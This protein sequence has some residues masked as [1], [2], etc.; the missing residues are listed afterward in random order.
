MTPDGV[1]LWFSHGALFVTPLCAVVLLTACWWR[2][3]RRVALRAAA[4]GLVW[5]ASFGFHYVFE[6]R[7]LLANPYL[8]NYWAFAFPPSSGGVNATMHWWLG[9]FEPFALKP[10]GTGRWVLFWMASI[11]GFVFAIWHRPMFGLMLI[12]VPISAALLAMLRIVPPHERLGLWIVPALY[13]S[14][15]MC[16]DA[17]GWLARRYSNRRQLTTLAAAV[18]AGAI[19][20][21]VCV[22][23]F[24]RGQ[25]ELEAKPMSNYGLDDRRSVGALLAL[26]R[27]GDVIVTTHF[28]LAGLWWYSGLRIA[29]PGAGGHLQ[30]GSP[31]YEI[32]HVASHRECGRSNEHLNSVLNDRSRIAVYLGFRLNV[33]PP[34]FD[35]LVLEELGQRGQ[36]VGYRRYAEDSHVAVF[37]LTERPAGGRLDPTTAGTLDAQVPRLSGCLDIREARRW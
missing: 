2:Q 13:A 37:D 24:R 21:L 18:C 17:P 23:V 8:Q 31:I 15:A 29:G 30:D 4:P 27:P 9:L 5:L 12:S 7:H 28:G 32:G 6:L 36:L 14:V 10:A 3:G 22:D 16:G 34:G 19:V 1:T 20:T 26:H 11:S 33:E 35:R 25:V